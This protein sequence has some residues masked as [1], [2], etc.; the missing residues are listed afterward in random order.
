EFR[1][2]LRR[3]MLYTVDV[4][5]PLDFLRILRA[6]DHEP[7]TGEAPGR[8][9]EQLLERALPVGAV[10]PHIADVPQFRPR[11]G[12][13]SPR[14]D[15]AVERGRAADIVLTL[16]LSEAGPA[17]ERQIEVEAP[18]LVGGHVLRAPRAEAGKRDRR[19]DVIKADEAGRA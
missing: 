7:T 17:G 6:R 9:Y 1:V 11:H 13:V 10:R 19:V 8:L 5:R 18:E 4:R 2:P 12:A 15:H 3:Q 16:Q 14:I